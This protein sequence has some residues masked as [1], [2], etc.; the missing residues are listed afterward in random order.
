MSPN[1][2]FKSGGIGRLGNSDTL[3]AGIRMG[4]SRGNAAP[5]ELDDW[6]MAPAMPYEKHCRCLRTWVLSNVSRPSYLGY[7]ARPA[8][9][10]AVGKG[11]R[12]LFITPETASSGFVRGKIGDND[13][14][15]K[16]GRYQ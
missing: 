6:P 15:P 12:E 7:L 5:G 16:W 1:P 14:W 4:Y 11:S 9:F 13:V 2:A 8:R 3:L 10:C